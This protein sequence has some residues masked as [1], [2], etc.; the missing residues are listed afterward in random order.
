VILLLADDV[1]DHQGTAG[2]LGGINHRL[3]L[4]DRAGDRLF[5]EDVLAGAQRGDGQLGV[6]GRGGAKADGVDV[7]A[8]EIGKL[9]AGDRAMAGGQFLRMLQAGIDDVT[10]TDEV[11]MGSVAVGMRLGDEPR[12]ADSDLDHPIPP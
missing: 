7:R 9:S 6:G 12:A 2:L 4:G 10:D 5:A 3:R 11:G 8:E 1:A